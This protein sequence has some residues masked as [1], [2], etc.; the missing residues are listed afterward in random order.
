DAARR[1][2]LHEQEAEKQSAEMSKNR[3]S[4]RW[5]KNCN[6]RDDDPNANQVF[7]L[8]PKRQR[9]QKHFLIG[10]EKAKSHQQSQNAARRAHRSGF[11]LHPEEMRIGDSNHYQGGAH[12]AERVAL[13]ESS[14]PPVA[15][16]VRADKPEREHVEKHVT[17]AG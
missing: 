11:R 8:D 2:E 17:E 1:Q 4:A 16:Q 9:K 3:D 5:L 10:V 15:F 12:D 7:G 6:D 13:D 14:R